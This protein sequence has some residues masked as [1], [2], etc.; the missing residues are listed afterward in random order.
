V[1]SAAIEFKLLGP[2][3]VTTDGELTPVTG[4]R[5]RALLAFLLLHRNHVVSRERLIDALWG[6]EPPATAANALQ[7]AVHELRK[8][9][10]RDRLLGRHGGYELVVRPGE[11][12]L[13][14]FEH[15]LR[16]EGASTG[17]LTRALALWRGS[18]EDGTYPEGVRREL[19]QLDE[20]R[21]TALERRIEADLARGANAGLVV[22][23]E[24]LVAE[25]PYRERFRAQLMLA[26]YRSGRQADALEAFAEARR[27]LI[28]DLGIEPGA[29]LRELESAILRQ[30]PGLAAPKRPHALDGTGLPTPPTPLVGR[31]LELAAVTGLLRPR[32][33]RLLTV[34]GPGGTGKTRLA[35]AVALEIASDYEDGA[36]FVDLAP[37]AESNLVPTAIA[38][39][40]GLEELAGETIV[41]TLKN[42][43]RD[44]SLL[45]VLDNFEHVLSAAPV[46]AELL[47]AA[48]RVSVLATSRAPLHLAAEQ[49][50]PLLPLELPSPTQ[51]V[52]PAALAHN[53]AVALFT[54]RTRATLPAFSVD[55]GNARAVVEICKALDG[56]P[57]AL[58]L[59]AARMKLLTPDALLERLRDRLDLL[60]ARTRDVPERQRTLRAT[61]D[62]SHELLEKPE[63]LLFMRLSVFAG[64]FSL[65]AAEAVCGADVE[66]LERL[67]DWSLVQPAGPGRFRM[68]DTVRQRAVER[69]EESGTARE[70]K[71]RHAEFFVTLAEEQSPLLRGAGA[72]EA[73]AA[74]SLELDNFRATLGFAQESGLVELQLRLSRALHR[75]AYL[76]GHLNEGR[77]WLETALGAAGHQPPRLR[78]LA[79]DAAG[80]IAWRQGDLAAAHARAAEALELMRQGGEELELRGPLSTLSV[81]AMDRGDYDGARPYQDEI[82]RL[83]RRFG[84]GYGLATALNN[85]AYIEWMTHDVAAAEARW[86][87]CV[88]AARDAGSG[89]LL[90]MAVSGLGDVALVRG[91]FDQA[92]ARFTEALA[93]NHE[94]G[95]TE[96]TAEMCLCLAAVAN[97]QGDGE[98]TARLLG[99][100]DALH[101]SVGSRVNISTQA[102]VAPAKAGAIAHLGEE[103][104]EAAFAQGREDA[105][106][107]VQEAL[108]R[109]P[110]VAEP[111]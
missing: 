84:D 75:F 11:L 50:Y 26:L 105:H 33:V 2:L 86:L 104:F 13:D 94:L 88:D 62:W 34:T 59:A 78:A 45:L 90:A 43:L 91:E 35:I 42:R 89:E 67:V 24:A 107:V 36:H 87:E 16:A 71:Q 3:E 85:Q 48:P 68:L 21:L 39:A 66:A 52:D 18:A 5:Q 83:A 37:L 17:D 27:R 70:A 7:V 8:H 19:A 41:E 95:F 74:L 82:A 51:A 44:R 101:E 99:A 81:V 69:L 22:E 30:D 15:A 109:S 49:E 10:G 1:G 14:Q 111:S 65:Q 106:E 6:D 12:D 38:G 60:T 20:L 76:R 57:L 56:L 79:L 110:A 32:D 102:Y 96:H 98:R 55:H 47:A 61:I 9:V 46:V 103:G 100:G 92:A 58:E 4:T 40:L 77:A 64:S 93:L 31:R 54:A 72:G 73:L 108:R 25:D 29:D 97:A 28:D 80:S 63:R 53:D 23:L